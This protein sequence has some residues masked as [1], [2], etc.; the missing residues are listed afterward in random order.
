MRIPFNLIK[1]V[2]LG[3]ASILMAGTAQAAIINVTVDFTASGFNSAA[4]Y[5]PIHGLI[6]FTFDNSTNLDPTT[7]GLTIIDF[8]LPSSYLPKFSYKKSSDAITF[9]TNLGAGANVGQSSVTGGND[10][11]SMYIFGVSTDP[12]LDSFLYASTTS[13]EIFGGNVTINAGVPEP[14]TWAMFILGFGLAGCSM[15]RRA[16]TTAKISFA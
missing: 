12:Y 13:A 11:F 16:G 14:T 1:G 9:G 8:T 6:N 7:T 4:P 10:Q 5:D 3:G 2:V 15:R